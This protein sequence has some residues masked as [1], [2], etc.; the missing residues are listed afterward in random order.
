MA[1]KDT[2]KK[3]QDLLEGYVY[4]PLKEAA[5][6]WLDEVDLDEA[7]AKVLESELVAQIKDAIPTVDEIIEKFSSK[8][9]IE[10]FGAETAEKIKAH[11]EELK[12][13]GIK[14]CDCEACTKAKSILS[15]FTDKAQKCLEDAVEQ[16][17]AKS[18][19]LLDEFSENVNELADK[20]GA[21]IDEKLK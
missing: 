3:V 13:K 4:E 14:Y 18:D 15:D 20:V 9:A 19:K 16:I 5:Q 1:D 10:Q 17:D 2:V 12:A 21:K 6:K 7:K 8:E 11:A